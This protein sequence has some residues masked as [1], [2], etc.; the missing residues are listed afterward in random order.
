MAWPAK[1]A[2]F[3]PHPGNSLSTANV[4]LAIALLAAATG[5]AVMLRRRAPY[6]LVGWLWYLG[7]LVPV[8]GLIQVGGQGHA[9]RYTYFPQLGILLALCWG[10]ADLAR[11]WPRI[12]SAIAAATALVL[13][14]TT[15][16][17]LSTWKDSVTLWQHDIDVTGGNRLAWYDL[18]SA[19]QERN[20]PKAAAECYSQALRYGDAVPLFPS[21][22]Q[23][24]LSLGYVLQLAGRLDDA[25]EQFEMLCRIDPDA[26][27]HAYLGNALFKR[28][29]LKP[30][31]EH[32]EESLR[33]APDQA[34]VCCTLGKIEGMLGQPDK[35]RDWFAKA[36]EIQPTFAGGY[37]GLGIVLFQQNHLADAQIQLNKALRCDKQYGQAHYYLGKVLATRRDLDNAAVHLEEA[38]RL[39]PGA[40]PLW[41]DLGQVCARQGRL[42]V[43]ANSLA[44][45]FELDP[46][47]KQ[48]QTGLATAL[49]ELVKAGKTDVARQIQQRVQRAT[50]ART[51]P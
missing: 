45:A 50:A 40:A 41:Y 11:G 12:A 22:A 8:I 25:I 26:N 1:L 13:A 29:Q 32:L 42:E 33:L 14:V 5:S 27:S 4:V 2:V 9:D 35:A 34:E 23:L 15:W 39:D 48:Y 37:C 18:G 19:R 46:R 24:L 43:A 6:L 17:Q 44:R 21:Q 51:G 3:Y 28:H 30:A 7:T 49:D 38:A 16:Q 36:V 47:S 20:D 10:I 31:A